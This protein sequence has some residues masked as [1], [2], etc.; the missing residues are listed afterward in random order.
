M[1]ENKL[2]EALLDVIPFPAYAVDINTYEV[3]YANKISKE[4]MYAPKEEF[5]WEKMY[6]Q[7][8]ICSWCS[9]FQLQ[10]QNNLKDNKL[11]HEFFDE[12]D[13]K[14]LTS[15]DEL[16]SWPDGREVK[17]S[18]LVDTTEQKEI[19][20]S[21]I[22]SHAKLAVKSKQIS[23]T[24]K[25]LQITKLNLQ[26]T[27]RELENS[28]AELQLLASTDPMTGLYNRRY[29][30][31]ITEHIF[32]IGKREKRN[33]SVL[34]LDI[35]NF[36]KINDNYGHK[37]GDEV[38][39][40][41]GA[42]LQKL[43]RKSDII[44]RFG[45]EE[46][47]ILLPDTDTNGA[48]SIAEKIRIEVQSIVLNVEETSSEENPLNFTVSIGISSINIQQDQNI[49]AAINRADNALYQAKDEGKNKVSSMIL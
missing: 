23:K 38:I 11:K 5:C 33:L 17:Y 7:T 8:Q 41:L 40:L 21:L 44:C 24:N 36:K 28:K 26:K 6:G 35:D 12:I 18:I 22:Q 45:G 34:M 20:G 9:I 30:S 39:K 43:A 27:I 15:Y 3:I 32:E 37:I 46:F 13:D 42:T 47:L 48:H 4:N 49:E 1:L 29:F 25:Q 10:Q 16:I 19:Q 31:N 2:F 14:W